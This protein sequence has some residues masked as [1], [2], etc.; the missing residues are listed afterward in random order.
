MIELS[1]YEQR[2]GL[3]Q[4]MLNAVMQ[5]ES[6]GNPQA[7]SPVGA[8]G[9]FQ[10]M[11][12]TARELGVDPF[13][14]EQAADGAARYLKQNYDQFGDWNLAL[15]AYNAGP[16]NV[17]K[18]G[19]VPPFQETQQYIEKVNSGMTPTTQENW[20]NRAKSI[21]N[22]PSPDWR[23]RATALT[24]LNPGQLENKAE[25]SLV[26]DTPDKINNLEG[27]LR[28]YTQG[29]TFGF[30]DEVVAGLS[31][32]VASLFTGNSISDSYNEILSDERGRSEQFRKEEP[33]LST[34]S[35]I[36]GAVG[37]GITGASTKAGAAIA[38]S[39]RT[40]NT[41][42]RVGK[43]MLTGAS[44][45][46][47]YG[48]GA[49][50]GEQRLKSAGQGAIL[51][52]VTGGAVP[53]IGAAASKLNTKTL[54]PASEDIR[55]AASN[56]FSQADEAGGVLK[57][58][59]A[60]EFYDNVLM[61][62]P[63][64]L[65][66]QVF[67]GKSAVADILDTIPSLKGKPMTLKAAQEIDEALGDL[68]YGTMDKFG[69]VTSEGKKFL[70]MQ[71]SLRETIEN[72]DESMIAGGK[73]GFN[74]LKKARNLW[75]TSLRL[76]DVEKI[77][78]NAQYYEQPTTAIKTGFRTLLRNSNRTKGFSKDEMKALK[79]AAET[80]IVTDFLR[81]AGSG[82]GPIIAGAGGAAATGGIAGS[83]A[84]VPAYAIQQGSK[85]LAASRQVGRASD[86]SK[87][88]AKRSGMVKTEQRLPI[89]RLLSLPSPTG[90]EVI[91]Q[92]PTAY[93]KVQSPRR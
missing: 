69:K 31:A 66:G 40:G 2:Y 87:V 55:K 89:D 36:G 90:R 57:S 33:L 46:G 64:T 43:S 23:G 13:N 41:A 74:K 39:L 76:R 6:A 15:A 53:A 25:Q 71:T 67:K 45:G 60:D 27:M 12:D 34:V 78:E 50:E 52:G 32:P 17:R 79:K 61:I 82:L 86:L 21:Q 30:G 11:P 93:T 84:A 37:T 19:G 92:T 35:E 68:A 28:S 22:A 85:K 91:N 56:L 26:V 14:P 72:A 4:G 63:Q 59:V 9:L 8:Q 49:G 77:I 48:Y 44:S 73:E 81:L 47:L 88:L 70:D 20:R 80:G 24:Q 54:I 38:N 62:R 65:E 5:T 7:V 42:T 16:G 58:D 51:G 83:L 75:S 29:N 10:F 1:P 18:Y 3:P